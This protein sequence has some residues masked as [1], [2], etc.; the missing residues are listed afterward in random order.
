MAQ[1]LRVAGFMTKSPRGPAVVGGDVKRI[2]VIVVL[3]VC[4]IVAGCGPSEPEFPAD[5]WAAV[6]SIAWDKCK[7]A[8]LTA[9]G[10]ETLI[11]DAISKVKVTPGSKHHPDLY[12]AIKGGGWTH[13]NFEL[14][15]T[16][17]SFSGPYEFNCHAIADKDDKTL[18]AVDLGASAA[19]LIGEPVE[20]TQC[21]HPKNSPISFGGF[22]EYDRQADR[23]KEIR[24]AQGLPPCPNWVMHEGKVTV[25][26]AKRD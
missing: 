22:E 26:P 24:A 16:Y 4:P 11:G 18:R 12:S 8:L 19:W 1:P 2:A 13:P 21:Y 9:L 20:E 23:V 25:E 6:Q 14:Y 7:S 17:V 5:E 3:L 15:G 10:K